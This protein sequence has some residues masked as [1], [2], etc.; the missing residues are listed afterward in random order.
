MPFSH[1]RVDV[2]IYYFS[3]LDVTTRR[4]GAERRRSAAKRGGMARVCGSEVRGSRVRN[5]CGVC[6]THPRR[7]R[8]CGRHAFR[9]FHISP[10]FHIS[11]FFVRLRAAFALSWVVLNVG[12]CVRHNMTILCTVWAMPSVCKRI[13]HV[14]VFFVRVAICLEAA[15]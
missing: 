15:T 7:S 6:G 12:G 9:R 2:P 4:F 10:A 11:N 13:V 5:A 1:H 14:V 8:I 3:F